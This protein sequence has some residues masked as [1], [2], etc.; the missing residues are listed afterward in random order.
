MNANTFSRRSILYR[1]LPATLLGMMFPALAKA[2][3]QPHMRSALAALK[4]AERELTAATPDKGGH[5]TRAEDLIRQAIRE[6]EQGISF[7]NRR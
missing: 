5:R 2:E 6:V 7:D 3:K 1:A 4:K